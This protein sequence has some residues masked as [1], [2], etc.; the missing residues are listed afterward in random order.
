M[1]GP[2]GKTSAFASCPAATGEHTC[3]QFPDGAHR[4]RDERGHIQADGTIDAVHTCTCGWEWACL[5]EGIGHFCLRILRAS[6]A[7][8]TQTPP[9]EGLA[10]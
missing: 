3:P 6:T 1:P 8:H 5:N 9:T 7:A 4:C 2:Y 10:T